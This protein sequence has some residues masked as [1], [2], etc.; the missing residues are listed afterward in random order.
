MAFDEQ[1]EN[2]RHQDSWNGFVK[3][4][5]WS[6]ISTIVVLGALALTLL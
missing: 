3:F 6:S 2:Q 4:L 5:T 1:A